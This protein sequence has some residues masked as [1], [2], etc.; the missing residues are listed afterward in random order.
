MNGVLRDGD[1]DEI[2]LHGFTKTSTTTGVSPKIRTPVRRKRSEDVTPDFIGRNVRSGVTMSPVLQ[3]GRRTGSRRKRQRRTLSI[4]SPYEFP[5]RCRTA[6]ARTT[7][8]KEKLGQLYELIL[9]QEQRRVRRRE[10]AIKRTMDR[11]KE[12][13][14]FASSTISAQCAYSVAFPGNFISSDVL[15]FGLELWCPQQFIPFHYLGSPQAHN[16]IFNGVGEHE[17]AAQQVAVMQRRCVRYQRVIECGSCLV[18]PY[19]YPKNV[20]WMCVLAWKDSTSNPDRYIVQPRNSL[21]NYRRYDRKCLRDA[22]KFLNGLYEY[23]GTRTRDLPKW[24]EMPTPDNICEQASGEMSCCLHTLAQA[25]LAFNKKWT[26]QSFSEEFI[27]TIRSNLLDQMGSDGVRDFVGTYSNATTATVRKG[28]RHR[29]RL[30]KQYFTQIKNLEKTKECRLQY[31]SYLKYQVGDVIQFQCGKQCEDRTV[32][33]IRRYSNLESM[34]SSE[35]VRACLPHLSESDVQKGVS[36]YLT[37]F[38]SADLHLGVLVFHLSPTSFKPE[39]KK[40][41]WTSKK[42]I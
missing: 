18:L 25:I 12:I 6:I 13:Q 15:M 19:N 20:H 5:V 35:T 27:H 37:F 3:K 16:F 38:K 42:K 32:V 11:M 14:V 29:M 23:A 31:Q 21:G 2:K 28:R 41:F 8:L 33:D 26:S 40:G 36:E 17:N 9:S 39:P 10:T 7:R 30:R 4:V 22:K 1:G 34:F 24:I